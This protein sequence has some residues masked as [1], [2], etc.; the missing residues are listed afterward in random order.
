VLRLLINIVIA[1][2]LIPGVQ[3]SLV[4][5]KSKALGFDEL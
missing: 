4:R 5:F 3:L 2:A 1:T